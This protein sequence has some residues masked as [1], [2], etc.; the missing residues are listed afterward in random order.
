M[1]KTEKQY[2]GSGIV[3]S[4]YLN[5]LA[6]GYNIPTGETSLSDFCQDCATRLLC[7]CDREGM[8]VHKRCMHWKCLPIRI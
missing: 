6:A 7:R 3:D 5:K 1:L 4:K 8:C 2:S